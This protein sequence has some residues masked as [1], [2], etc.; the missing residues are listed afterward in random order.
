MFKLTL[1]IHTTIHTISNSQNY[2][3]D[4]SLCVIHSLCVSFVA[5][6]VVNLRAMYQFRTDVSLNRNKTTALTLK[7]CKCLRAVQLINNCTPYTY[8]T[9]AHL[10]YP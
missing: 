3:L 6:A 10:V 5:V 8:G 1:F 9:G 2:F 7:N 4:C